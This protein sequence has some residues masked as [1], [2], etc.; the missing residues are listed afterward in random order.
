MSKI[1]SPLLVNAAEMAREYPETFL[2]P[3]KQQL[4][5]IAPKD[6]VKVSDDRERFWVQVTKRNGEMLVGRVDSGLLFQ[7]DYNYGDLIRFGTDNIY[8]IFDKA[9]FIA[10]RDAI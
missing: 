9:A 2:R 8:E 6:L 7:A 10:A 3:S 4:D 1:Q 5:H